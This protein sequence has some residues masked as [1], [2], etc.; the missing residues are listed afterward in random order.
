ME[1][2]CLLGFIGL[3]LYLY[4]RKC[5]RGDLSDIMSRQIDSLQEILCKKKFKHYSV[6]SSLANVNYIKVIKEK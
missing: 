1:V 3:N 6:I 4:K 5:Y 2:I